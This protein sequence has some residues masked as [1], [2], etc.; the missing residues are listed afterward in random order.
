MTALILQARLDSS[1]LPEKALLPLG[2]RPLVLRVMEALHFIP[3]G[4]RILACAKDSASAFAPL[5]E[6]A[7]F[8]LIAG[9]KDDVLGR[10]CLA[11]RH[12]GADRIIRATGDNP[13]AFTDAAAVINEEAITQNA[14]YAGYSGLPHGAGVESVSSEALL[15]SEKEAQ[16]EAQREHVCPYLYDNPGLFRLHRP[17]APGRWQAPALRITID[18]HDDYSRALSLYEALSTLPPEERNLGENVINAITALGKKGE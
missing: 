13:F 8:T 5:V 1:R 7:G 14:D 9:P 4:A 15:R 6:E 10:F 3:C 2:G 12:C 16:T 17:L 11:I 18:T